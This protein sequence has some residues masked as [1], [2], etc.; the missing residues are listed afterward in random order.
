MGTE[1]LVPASGSVPADEKDPGPG[2]TSAEALARLR[3][4]GPNELPRQKSR[5]GLKLIGEIVR[6]PMILLLLASGSIYLLLGDPGEA[7]FLLGSIGV[8]IAIEF[9]QER[10]TERA[11][12]ALR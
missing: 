10:K 6:E 7:L 4:E 5:R 2:L 11:L 12:E 9:F 3:E 1:I 8:V